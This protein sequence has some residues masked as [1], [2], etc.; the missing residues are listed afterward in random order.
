MKIHR[1]ILRNRGGRRIDV[2]EDESILDACNAAGIVLP[3]GCR[4]GGCITCAAKL[5]AGKVVQPGATALKKRQS[6]A[7]YV[8]LCVARPR[9]DCELLVGVESHDELYRNP[10]AA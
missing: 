5:V 8:L 10:F 1:V 7:G 4:Y 6:R 2:R 9:S 3:V